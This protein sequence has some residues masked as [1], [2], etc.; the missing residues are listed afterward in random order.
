MHVYKELSFVGN[1]PG[2]DSLAKNI[3]TEM[4]FVKGI[5]C[6]VFKTPK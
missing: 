4:R 3:Y 6:E 1:K 2:L 5:F